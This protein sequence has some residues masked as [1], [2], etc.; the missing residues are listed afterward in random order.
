MERISSMKL[1]LGDSIWIYDPGIK[2]VYE[3]T[4]I[5]V[6]ATSITTKGDFSKSPVKI[7]AYSKMMKHRTYDHGEV[8]RTELDA[9]GVQSKLL[10]FD[11]DKI[12]NEKFK[13]DRNLE[14]IK[15]AA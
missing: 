4:V 15:G 6:E 10:Q 12:L 11:A 3:A 13:V 7:T 5:G 14:K 2:H 8:H 1:M 9:L